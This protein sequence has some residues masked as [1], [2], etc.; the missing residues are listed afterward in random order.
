VMPSVGLKSIA[1]EKGIVFGSAIDYPADNYVF[2][3]PKIA[4]IISRES[5]VVTT[6]YQL[7]E[8]QVNPDSGP[9]RFNKA[10]KVGTFAQ[11]N[12]I[13]MA[14]HPLVWH[15]DLPD[16]LKNSKDANAVAQHMTERITD[17]VSRYKGKAEYW[18]VVNEAI[19]P[20][21]MRPDGLRSSPYLDAMGPE[22]IEKAFRAARKADPGAL[23]VLNEFGLEQDSP[24]PEAKRAKVLELLNGMK[25]RGVPIDAL[26]IESHLRSDLPFD[27][28]GFKKFTQSVAD[29]G[30]K[31]FVTELDV[32]DRAFSKDPAIRDRQSANLVKDYLDVVL[33]NKDTTHLITWGLFDKYSWYNPEKP[34]PNVSPN[35]LRA[36]RNDGTPHRPLLY[37]ENLV[38]TPMW[39][40]IASAL[41]N[42]PERDMARRPDQPKFK[43]DGH[44]QEANPS[45][46]NAALAGLSP[47]ARAAL[48]KI[49][50]TH[51]EHVVKGL[52]ERFAENGVM[53][54]E[55]MCYAGDAQRNALAEHLDSANNTTL[56]NLNS[57]DQKTF[58]SLSS[59]QQDAIFSLA[60]E[61]TSRRIAGRFQVEFQEPSVMESPLHVGQSQQ[62]SK[63]N[64]PL[65][66]H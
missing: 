10:D 15:D 34:N 44:L 25:E 30:V 46:I 51:E 41:H 52:A 18:V 61:L 4:R 13:M 27:R 31:I 42:A 58:G 14:G 38:K 62:P 11:Q 60:N 57:R 20:K 2:T 6:G 45:E 17:L 64:K 66:K 5:A 24:S 7:D 26:G 39:Y 33:A 9:A 48:N 1:E 36:P 37:G 8:R 40:A 55:A 59:Q 47:D 12:G 23:L 49:H 43:T 54:N 21:S 35:D 53:A 19:D 63:D 28:E 3:D 22:Y 65:P 32:D 16:W 56:A 29:L 50:N